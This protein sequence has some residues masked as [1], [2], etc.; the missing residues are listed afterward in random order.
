V[1]N[2][3]NISSSNGKADSSS[4]TPSNGSLNNQT[5]AQRFNEARNAVQAQIEKMFQDASNNSNG[6]SNKPPPQQE[7]AGP[8]T[9]INVRGTPSEPPAPV[10]NSSILKV[11]HSK[12]NVPLPPIPTSSAAPVTITTPPAPPNPTPS[13][14][15]TN[16]Y[17]VDYLG[18]LSLPGR[19]T[20][21]ESL[22]YPLKELYSLYRMKNLNSKSVYRGTM[23]ISPAG[24]RILYSTSEGLLYFFKQL[25]RWTLFFIIKK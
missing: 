15:N 18:S 25:T 21:L 2:Q 10:T 6:N 23:E 7:S 20:S 24:L 4:I 11:S 3:V 19:A 1:N 8:V 14:G 9:I 5:R 12:Q 16:Q 17:K 13:A 22:Q